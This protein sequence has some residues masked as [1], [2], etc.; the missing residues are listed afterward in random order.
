MGSELVQVSNLQLALLKIFTLSRFYC[1]VVHSLP[2]LHLPS[3]SPPPGPSSPDLLSGRVGALFHLRVVVVVTPKKL[4]SLSRFPPKNLQINE[5]NCESRLLSHCVGWMQMDGWNV[6]LYSPS[7]H[8]RATRP[9]SQSPPP[10]PPPPPPSQKLLF[11]PSFLPFSSH[12]LLLLFFERCRQRR[13]R[14]P[15]L[16]KE[17]EEEEELVQLDGGLL[18]AAAAAAAAAETT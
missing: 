2:S 11:L 14:R 12:N 10:P 6:G 9:K 4:F 18:Q 1:I 16:F 13:R 17:E 8:T 5:L 15:L 3:G 7:N